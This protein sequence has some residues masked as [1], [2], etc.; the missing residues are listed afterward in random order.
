MISKWPIAQ[1]GSNEPYHHMHLL[2]VFHI[3]AHSYFTVF[4]GPKQTRVINVRNKGAIRF[5][6]ATA[7]L[8][9]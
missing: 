1:S 6:A 2:D 3:C 5:F 7:Q 4:P 9:E 8:G